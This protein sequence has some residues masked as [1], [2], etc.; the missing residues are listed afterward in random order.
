MDGEV[1]EKNIVNNFDDFL[2]DGY[3]LVEL[4]NENKYGGI[5]LQRCDRKEYIIAHLLVCKIESKDSAECSSVIK[6]SI[7]LTN[8]EYSK[9]NIYTRECHI[10]DDINKWS[11]WKLITGF[12]Y[13]GNVKWQD[14]DKYTSSGVYMGMI[15]ETLE[16]FFMLCIDNEYATNI[17]A[18][19]TSDTIPKQCFQQIY[20]LPV[21]VLFSTDELSNSSVVDYPVLAKS[22]KRTGIELDDTWKW[23]DWSL[24]DIGD[25]V[26]RATNRENELEYKLNRYYSK[27]SNIH[28]DEDDKFLI[29]DRDGNTVASIDREGIHSIDYFDKN[30]NSISKIVEST[31][32]IYS[33]NEAELYI[34]DKYGN[35]ILKIDNTGLSVVDIKVSSGVLNKSSLEGKYLYSLGASLST[36]GKWQERVAEITGMIFDKELNYNKD[37]SIALSVGG[38][39]T[40]SHPNGGFERAQRLVKIAEN[41]P[42]DV[43]IIENGNDTAWIKLNTSKEEIDDWV[44]NSIPYFEEQCVDVHTGKTNSVDA[45]NYFKNNLAICLSGIEMKRNTAIKLLYN[46]LGKLLTITGTATSDGAITLTVGDT[47]YN[48]NVTTSMS[49]TDIVEKI[50]EID[51]N[52][53]TDTQ[54]NNNSV[55]FV[56]KYDTKDPNILFTANDTGVTATI[57]DKSGAVGSYS[58]S[59]DSVPL[60][61]DN[62]LNVDNWKDAWGHNL[63][64]IMKG[65]IEYLMINIPNAK[66]I[67]CNLTHYIV[68]PNELPHREDGSIDVTAFNQTEGQKRFEMQA[69]IIKQVCNYY[70]IPYIDLQYEAGINVL[71]S[72]EYYYEG[73]VHPKDCCY[74]LWGDEIAK[75]ILH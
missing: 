57:A 8:T 18:D 47:N 63:V 12:F 71:N 39:Q 53:Y 10:Y 40:A 50:L 42:V 45:I 19:T 6:Q 35:V 61:N 32:N 72:L 23:S 33:A 43:V 49:A 20:L 31:S 29:S 67:W 66:I 3:Y 28:N 27:L 38:S 51:F 22:K 25:E 36:S 55:L 48:I 64:E 73:D 4:T 74:R 37:N 17:I 58:Y 70:R 60:N 24:S 7:L 16:S 11:D 14:V 2:Y 68:R 52:N 65:I 30:G 34:T 69:Y 5:P 54:E 75:R 15:E 41:R 44:Q 1:I 62:W 21:S 13:V 56:Y 26:A 9:M 59:F 46:K